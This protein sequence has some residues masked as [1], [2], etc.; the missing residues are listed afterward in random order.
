MFEHFANGARTAVDAA[1][2]EA[3][4]R[5][6]RRIGTE[7]LLLGVLHAPELATLRE[8]GCDVDRARGALDELDR[9]ALAAVG[10]DATGVERPPIPLAPR[11]APL[12]SG[13]QDVLR[14]SLGVVRRHGQRRITPAHLLLVLLD[15][16][17][18]DPAAE[19][20]HALGLDRTAVREHLQ[21]QPSTHGLRPAGG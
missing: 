20:C 6:D 8:L 15:A 18:P 10:V 21:R 7:H 16:D 12:T 13:A 1:R 14:R 3:R 4:R 17:R 2:E 5:G 19:V 11:R 9:E